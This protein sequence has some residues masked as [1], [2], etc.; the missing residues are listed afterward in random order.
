MKTIF[1]TEVSKSS[2]YTST[3]LL[4]Q[5]HCYFF[6]SKKARHAENTVTITNNWVESIGPFRKQNIHTLISRGDITQRR[7]GLNCFLFKSSAFFTQQF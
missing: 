1:G 6:D 5:E 7:C 3:E 2:P 4:I